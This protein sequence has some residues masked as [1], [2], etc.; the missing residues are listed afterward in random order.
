MKLQLNYVVSLRPKS[1]E[2]RP[3]DNILLFLLFE[4]ARSYDLFNMTALS[5]ENPKRRNTEH[6]GAEGPTHRR[7]KTPKSHD[8]SYPSLRRNIISYCRVM[9][10]LF[11]V[12]DFDAMAQPS[13]IRI[14][15]RQVVFLCWKQD[16]NPGPQ[17]PICQQTECSQGIYH[18]ALI[19]HD[20]DM[21]CLDIMYSHY[22][23]TPSWHHIPSCWYHV[24]LI[25]CVVSYHMIR[26][27]QQLIQYHTY[28]SKPRQ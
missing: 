27:F 17:T 24:M 7:V 21:Y 9:S 22:N 14:E 3:L 25:Y 6:R 2:K 10:Y 12:V 15:R 20:T 26:I 5:G 23:N 18:I 4:I 19:H 13:D 1:Q 16:L 11:V 28:T 8:T